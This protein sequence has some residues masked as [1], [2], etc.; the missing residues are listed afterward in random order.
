[1]LEKLAAFELPE[2]EFPEGKKMEAK[3]NL[4]KKDAK[5]EK[6]LEKELETKKELEIE[7]MKA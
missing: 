2:K 1:M 4:L 5:T 6:V 3:N 7:K